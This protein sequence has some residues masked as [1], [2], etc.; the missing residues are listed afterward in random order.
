MGSWFRICF[1]WQDLLPWLGISANKF[2]SNILSLTLEDIA[3]PAAKAIAVQQNSLDFL[4]KAI[5]NNRGALDYLLSEQ[6][7]G[8]AVATATCCTWINTSKEVE[9]QLHKI[10]EQATLLKKVTLS[11]GSFFDLFDYDWFGSWGPWLWSILQASGII[12]LIIIIVVS[13]VCGILS[14]DLNAGSQLLTTKQIISLR[15]KCQ[16]RNKENDLLKRL[17]TWCHDLWILQ[18]FSK[19]TSWPVNASQ[20]IGKSCKNYRVVAESGANALNFDHTCQL[21]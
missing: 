14:K 1:L 11:T 18:R 3:E 2:T 15:L 16:R 19:K 10:A 20:R 6:R 13:L 7:G 9:T 5:L 21:S 17:W 8:C 4:A 12:L